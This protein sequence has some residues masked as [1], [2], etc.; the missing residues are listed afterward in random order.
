MSSQ[1]EEPLPPATRFIA[2]K[3]AYDG[4]DFCGSQIQANGRT[5]QGDLEAALLRVLGQPCPAILAGRTDSGV[6]ASGQVARFATLNQSLP[7]ERVARALN[8]VMARDLRVLQAWQVDGEFHP[9]FSATS[10][11]YRYRIDVSGE[12]NPLLRGIATQLGEDLDT[13]AMVAASRPLLGRQDFAAWQSAGSPAPSTVREIKQVKIW[14]SE[15]FGSLLIEI[16]IEADAFLYQM[17]R[18]IVGALIQAGR[19]LITSEDVKR[20]T[21]GLDR[22]L[23]PPPAAPQGLCLVQVN[24]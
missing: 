11:I 10:R 17:V 24:Y 9:R 20:L 2:M 6:H 12:P 3:V 4:T 8:G 22:K 16:E 7:V 15:S 14:R 13:E 1:S 5:V 23:C 19:G 21:L 18:N